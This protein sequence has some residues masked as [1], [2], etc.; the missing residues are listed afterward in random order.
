MCHVIHDLFS[1][2]QRRQR[3]EMPGVL[4]CDTLP[5]DSK[6]QVG[7][8]IEQALSKAIFKPATMQAID[9]LLRVL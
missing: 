9:K 6:K 4:Q 5:I 8:L 2:R 3:G 1:K 7:M